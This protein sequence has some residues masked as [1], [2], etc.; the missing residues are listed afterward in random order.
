MRDAGYRVRR[1]NGSGYDCGQYSHLESFNFM[2]IG[3][4]T[5]NHSSEFISTRKAAK[6]LG[7][8]LTTVQQWVESGA[9]P[10]WKT[11]GGHRRIPVAAIEAIRSR[12]EAVLG[13]GSGTAS[14]NKVFKILVVEDEPVQRELYGQQLA[15]WNL[16]IEVFTAENGFEGLILVGRRVPDL[17]ITDLAMPGMNGFEMIRNLATHSSMF[18][19]AVIVVTALSPEQIAA[20][21]GLPPGIPIYPKPVS[22]TALRPL[23]E[24]M[25]RKAAAA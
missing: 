20:A 1:F 8:G 23:V 22:F 12:Q 11:A 25:V 19:G 17:I 6:L 15:A 7:V 2:S 10:A 5:M 13:T 18:S 24:L 21:G 4:A 9:L 16:P 3:T 14:A